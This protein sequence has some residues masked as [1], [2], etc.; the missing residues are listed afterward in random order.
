MPQ[1]PDL[2]V[3]PVTKYQFYKKSPLNT[4]IAAAM[5]VAILFLLPLL[6]S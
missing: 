2:T 6:L 3:N 5:V 1:H 4:T